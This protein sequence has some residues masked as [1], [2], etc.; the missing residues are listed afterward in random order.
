M[1]G[2]AKRDYPA[3]IGHQSPWYEEYPMIED[4]FARLG[5]VLTRGTP[6]VRVGVVHPIESY[7]LH[8]GP[9]DHGQE[10]ED[11]ERRFT[12]LTEWLLYG[13]V[14]FDFIC[15]SLLPSQYK[16]S[17]DK[18]LHVGEMAYD[19][20]LVPACDTLRSTTLDALEQF[21]ARGGTVIFAGKAPCA[22]DALPSS[23]PAALAAHCERVPF[24]RGAVLAALEPVREL[25]IR[26]PQGDR[27]DNL[28]AQLRDDGED[29]WLFVSHCNPPAAPDD[30]V[31]EHYT[32]T[33]RGSWSATWY[34]TL[35]GRILTLES[36]REGDA[37]RLEWHCFCY[38]SLLLRLCPT[39]CE[40][41]E[42]QKAFP[43]ISLPTR[44]EAA[45]Q[46]AFPLCR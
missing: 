12:E 29:R 10:S 30:S 23:R 16:P 4:H 24:E 19:A 7:W 46:C 14:D 35:T 11:I 1:E 36:V 5:T 37:T 27:S 6:R 15:E 18:T 31:P 40:R 43:A 45:A 42:N 39:A 17:A 32:L 3:S 34:D 41:Q 28:I 9:L 38:D 22:Q 20:V 2:E 21:S 25:D 33:L 13:L 44:P 26:T 8:Y